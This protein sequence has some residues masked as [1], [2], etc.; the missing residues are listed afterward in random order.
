MR[1]AI[2]VAPVVALLLAAAACEVG[3]GGLLVGG[4]SGPASLVGVWTGTEEITGA[5]DIGEVPVG[6]IEEGVR[7]PVS[8]RLTAKGRFTLRV[9]GFPVAAGTESRVCRGVYE[10]EGRTLVFFPDTTCRPLPLSRYVIGRTLPDGLT[11]E[12]R[13]EREATGKEPVG[14]IRVFIDVQRD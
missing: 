4:V 3:D 7:F 12:A 9:F 10:G 13:T 11:L 1:G 6:S 5:D 2:T 8:L 14:D